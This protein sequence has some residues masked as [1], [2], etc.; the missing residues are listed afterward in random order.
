MTTINNSQTIYCKQQLY[1]T[2]FFKNTCYVTTETPM[3][4]IY[5]LDSIAEEDDKIVIINL[6][7][8]FKLEYEG[9][10]RNGILKCK[11]DNLKH[12]YMQKY[13]LKLPNG[14]KTTTTDMFEIRDENCTYSRL[15]QV[16]LEYYYICQLYFKTISELLKV[17]YGLDI[18]YRRVHD[19]YYKYIDDFKLMKFEDVKQDIINKK[20][21]LGCVANYDEEFCFCK[22]QNI[23]RMTIIDYK[24]KLILKDIVVPR[25]F[26]DRK[27]I[28]EF[29]K[30]A[31][32]CLGYH[33]IVTDGNKRY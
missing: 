21:K 9:Y 10:I 25:K 19:I 18:D 29:I 3:E 31:V 14:S 8:D 7:Q 23:V 33:T 30:K 22:H 32:K 15:G 16:I 20:I 27:L 17:N 4:D 13:R 12:I 1:K 2:F 24:S 28:K 26:F 11:L 6:N 5:H